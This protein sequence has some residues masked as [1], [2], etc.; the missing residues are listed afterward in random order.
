M[1]GPPGHKMNRPFLWRRQA[2]KDFGDG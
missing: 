2:G 1:P